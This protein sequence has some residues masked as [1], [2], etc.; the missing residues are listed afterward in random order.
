[1]GDLLYVARQAL[2]NNRLDDVARPR[3][4]QL[5]GN[6]TISLDFVIT[7]SYTNIVIIVPAIKPVG[8][9]GIGVAPTTPIGWF[10]YGLSQV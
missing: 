2:S 7:R 10:E 8:A 9:P 3:R 1:M 4:Y 6:Q 5:A